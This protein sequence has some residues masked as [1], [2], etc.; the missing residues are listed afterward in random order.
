[1][2]NH[3]MVDGQLLQKDKKFSDLKN[4]QK[5]RIAQ[6]LY[7]EYR[8]V[9]ADDGGKIGREAEEWL[10]CAVMHKIA[11]QNIWIPE[12]EIWDYYR[13]KKNH[14]RKRLD[15]ESEDAEQQQRL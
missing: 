5:D 15:K 11:E 2:K 1:M 4:A 13:R 12:S 7:E 8:R 9:F 14:L 6:W 10:I 3:I